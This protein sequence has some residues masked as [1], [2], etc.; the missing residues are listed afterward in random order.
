M[1]G[2]SPQGEDDSGKE[3][4]DEGVGKVAHGWEPVGEIAPGDESSEAGKD[5]MATAEFHRM[6]EGIAMRGRAR[7]M[8]MVK[9][10]VGC[11]GCCNLCCWSRRSDDGRTSKLFTASL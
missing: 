11:E 3:T 9:R 4:S 8:R 6:G 7:Q 2:N 1:E 5:H 10:V